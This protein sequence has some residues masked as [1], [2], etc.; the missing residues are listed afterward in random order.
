MNSSVE[1]RPVPDRNPLLL[2]LMRGYRQR[3]R[4]RERR[5][6]TEHCLTRRSNLIVDLEPPTPGGESFVKEPMVPKG[7]GG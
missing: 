4:Y 1:Y 7:L 6:L 3:Y 5:T 2:N